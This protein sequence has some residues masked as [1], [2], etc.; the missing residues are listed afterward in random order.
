MSKSNKA[1]VPTTE[2][3]DLDSYSVDYE[4]AL[5]ALRQAELHCHV[6]MARIAAIDTE[7]LCDAI[8][9]DVEDRAHAHRMAARIEAGDTRRA[10]RSG[11]WF[12]LRS[13]A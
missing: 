3:V 12:R 2:S 10:I 9:R 6:A 7:V 5:W 13:I 8:V 11:G 1:T 4:R